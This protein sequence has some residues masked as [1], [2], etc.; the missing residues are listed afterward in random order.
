MSQNIEDT[1]FTIR[2]GKQVFDRRATA[3]HVFVYGKDAGTVFV[4]KTMDKIGRTTKVMASTDGYE[5]HGAWYGEV[6]RSIPGAVL[7]V[8]AQDQF[9]GSPRAQ[10]GVFV[11][12]N[13]TAPMIKISATLCEHHLAANTEIDVFVGRGHVLS[14]DEVR[15]LGYQVKKRFED[16]FFDQE[17]IDELITL[18]ELMSGAEKP[19]LEE[20]TNSKGEKLKVFID[21]QPKRKLRMRRSK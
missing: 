12:L 18:E 19:V 14:P 21:Q 3:V 10:A 1:A 15:T 9:N 13:D 6:L 11:Q 8:K 20:V 7:L 2:W 16:A 4:N 17:E 5:D